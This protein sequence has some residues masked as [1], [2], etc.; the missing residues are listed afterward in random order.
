MRQAESSYMT[1]DD[2]PEAS[3]ATSL[4]NQS[5]SSHEPA[6]EEEEEEEKKEDSDLKESI[7]EDQP[8]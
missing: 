3:T 7:I 8:T 5:V 1:I 4:Q 2:T 6:L